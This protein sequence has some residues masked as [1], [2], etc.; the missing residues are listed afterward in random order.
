MPIYLYLIKCSICT[1]VYGVVLGPATISLKIQIVAKTSP[2]LRLTKCRYFL[3]FLVEAESP[4]SQREFLLDGPVFVE[5]ED[6]PVNEVDYV[7]DVADPDRH[8]VAQQERLMSHPGDEKDRCQSNDDQSS[9]RVAQAEGI[10]KRV[11]KREKETV[12]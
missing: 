3:C 12:R 1:E 8:Q 2:I 9:R 7:R 4:T 6:G 10:P 11:D 5:L